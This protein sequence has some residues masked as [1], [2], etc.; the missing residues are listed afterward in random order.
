MLSYQWWFN[1]S[2]VAG[3]TAA[4]L[5][6]TNLQVTNAGNYWAVITNASGSTNSAV[7]VLKVSPSPV[8]TQQPQS[9]AVVLGSTAQFSV[10]ASSN[11]NLT[12]QW[13]HA[14]TNLVSQTN[15]TLS[16]LSVQASDIGGYQV[17]VNTPD[18]STV[19]GLAHL[20]QA[21]QPSMSR[22]RLSSGTA[23]LTFSTEIGPVYALQ[24]KTNL[25]DALWL[26]LTNLD[27]TGSPATVTDSS[28][29]NST[30]FYRIQ[31]R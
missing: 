27:G 3:A 17:I 23:S 20:T 18:C 5:N 8:I 4:T 29:T 31:V 21:V 2:P 7:A 25:K 30:R 24:Y 9:R 22:P 15:A 28:I 16:L 11:T 19:S 1:D 12:Y 26:E 10:V 6:L 13:Q 14:A